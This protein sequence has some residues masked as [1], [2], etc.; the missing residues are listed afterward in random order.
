MA[1]FPLDPI[2]YIPRGGVLSDGGGELRKQS[3][4][5]SLSGQHIR[6]NEDIALA[7]CDENFTALERHEFLLHIHHHLTQVLR[8]QVQ[9]YDMQWEQWPAPAVDNHQIPQNQDE[10]SIEISGLSIGLNSGST[11]LSGNNNNM[12]ATLNRVDN[13]INNAMPRQSSPPIQLPHMPRPP[14]KL[15]YSRRQRAATPSQQLEPNQGMVRAEGSLSR[16]SKGKGIM[17]EKPTLQQ[18]TNAVVDEQV[19]VDKLVN[20]ELGNVGQSVPAQAANTGV[21]DEIN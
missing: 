5:V 11:A 6:R 15:V 13:S 16:D 1:N 2:T 8:L 10:L 21:D 20:E 12:S 14:I 3:T 18:F 19:V 9:R 17:A 4:F 7:V